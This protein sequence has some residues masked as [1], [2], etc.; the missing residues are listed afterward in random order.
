MLA[1]AMAATI[2]NAAA[3]TV[4]EQLR[5]LQQQNQTLLGLVEK[6]QQQIDA[7]NGRLERIV[8]DEAPPASRAAAAPTRR[9][10]RLIVSGEFGLS[11]F[12]GSSDAQY[13]NEE[14]RVD[15]SNVYLEAELARGLYAFG[16][17]Q[18]SR[19]EALDEAYKIG[20]LYLEWENV[21]GRWTAE[22]L[23]NLRFGRVD[24]PFGEEYLVRTPLKNSLVTHSL[25]DVWGTDEGLVV[26]GEA[27]RFDYALAVQNGGQQLMRDFDSD[28]ALTVRVGLNPADG[29]RISA[30]AY[31]TGE[32]NAASEPLSEI[33]I[34]NNV[35]RSIGSPGTSRYEGSLW[36]L[37]LRYA[38]D[39]G[40]VL[41]AWGGARYDDNDPLADNAR[42][43][44][45]FHLEAMQGFGR[46]LYGAVRYS[47][48]EA[49]EGY[50][51]AGLGNFGKYFLGSLFTEDLW[52]AS[53]GLGYRFN[54][55]AVL[56]LELTREERTLAGGAEGS[57]VNQVSA[58]AALGF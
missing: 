24:V 13:S 3:A 7:L 15:D 9:D 16:E 11:F 32:L 46:H 25:G 20:E 4:E 52:R 42:R 56:K 28:K 34:G 23:V 54:P 14:F 17:I 26:F 51:L 57:A 8:A 29:W 39:D 48:L 35:F 1:A 30:S 19:R 21:L 53:A 6:Q 27:G 58:Q 41:G 49:D 38:W 36:Q 40:H 2:V 44:T 33:W 5:A 12:G 47:R 50:P 45:S 55:S 31:R 43:F 10:V 37:D 22:R 18:L